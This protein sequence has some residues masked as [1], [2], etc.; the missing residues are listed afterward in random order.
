M[1]RRL[2]ATFAFAAAVLGPRVTGAQQPPAATPT[3][4]F[5]TSL[6]IQQSTG[7]TTS[8][9]VTGEQDIADTTGTQQFSLAVTA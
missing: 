9:A 6:G 2:A 3:W 1:L 4:A 8:I 7:S 5:A